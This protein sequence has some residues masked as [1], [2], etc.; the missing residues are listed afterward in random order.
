MAIPPPPL[1]YN[2]ATDADLE[3]RLA[4]KGLKVVEIYSGWCGP[5][6]SVLPTFRRIRLDKDDENALLFL[7]VEAEKCNFLEP[8][9]E[10]RGKSE[11]LFLLYRNG[12]LKCRVE[13]ANTP[14]LNIE[15][16]SLTPANADTDDLEEN[17]IYIALQER[18]TGGT[19]S[20]SKGKKKK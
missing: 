4:T 12:Q 3:S 10:H 11:P 5:C 2:I 18:N 16:L 13:G 8:A 7:T 20:S 9:K 17:P 1:Q 19:S 14:R 15:I 6:K